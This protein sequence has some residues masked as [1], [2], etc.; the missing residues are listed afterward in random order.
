MVMHIIVCVKQVLDT[1][2]PLRLEEG[3]R[4]VMQAEPE[5][6]LIMDPAARAALEEAMVLK[7][8]FGAHVTTITAGPYHA[9]DVLRVC[10]ARGAD[11]AVHVLCPD[12]PSLDG[13]GTSLALSEEIRKHRYDLLLCGEKSLDQC[14]GLVGPALAERLNLPQ[15]TRV[16]ELE[17]RPGQQGLTAQRLLERGDR[18]FIEGSFP[19]LVTMTAT[20]CEPRYVSVHRRLRVEGRPIERVTASF[21]GGEAEGSC[22]TVAVDWPRPRPKKI[23]VPASTM[24]AAERMQFLMTGGRSAKKERV[25]RGSAQEGVET[26]INFLREH[27][28]V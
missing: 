13:W 26:I 23:A 5:P 1:Q 19:A 22:H 28:F 3:S 24:S 14:A 17:V 4:V 11:E 15:I 9:E 16:V 10:L 20:A 12:E 27:G 2:V 7:R 18:E 25:F 21:P 6:I 8:C